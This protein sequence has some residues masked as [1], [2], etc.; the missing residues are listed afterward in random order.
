M[1]VD[2]SQAPEDAMAVLLRIANDG[3]QPV[4]TRL[5]A[6]EAALGYQQPKL[7]SSVNRN[8][9]VISI[10]D[11]LDAARKRLQRGQGPLIEH[12]PDG[13]TG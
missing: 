12:D 6:A 11:E 9:N 2:A 8:E 1:S 3:E 4:T 10:G 7:S 5:R 13:K